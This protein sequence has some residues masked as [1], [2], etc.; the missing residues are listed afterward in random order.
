VFAACDT[1]EYATGAQRETVLIE[2]ARRIAPGMAIPTP[3]RGATCRLC[4]RQAVR[5]AGAQP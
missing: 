5:A 3:G 2:E 1:N 4:L